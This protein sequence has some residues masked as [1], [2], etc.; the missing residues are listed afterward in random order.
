ME[1]TRKHLFEKVWEKP[2]REVAKELGLSDVGLAKLCRRSAIPLPGQGY[3]L[4]SEKRRARVVQPLLR[5]APQGQPD[6]LTFSACTGEQAVESEE[7]AFRRRAHDTAKAVVAASTGPSSKAVILEVDRLVRLTRSNIDRRRVDE[8]GI[9]L[10]GG[11]RPWMVRTSPKQVDRCA[12][13]ILDRHCSE[14]P[15]A[16]GMSYGM[17]GA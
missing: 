5:P 3:W 11:D 16:S 14:R 1:L 12:P 2:L 8:R 17:I 4:I 13:Q 10:G 7:D 6:V 9:L 15:N